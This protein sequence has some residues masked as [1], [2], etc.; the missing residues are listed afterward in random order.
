MIANCGCIMQI[1]GAAAGGGDYVASFF[2]NI[3]LYLCIKRVVK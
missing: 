1:G 2:L 3:L